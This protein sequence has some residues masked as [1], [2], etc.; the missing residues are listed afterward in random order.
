MLRGLEDSKELVY[1]RREVTLDARRQ[2]RHVMI[3]PTQAGT[4]QHGDDGCRMSVPT[5]LEFQ[6][7]GTVDEVYHG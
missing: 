6:G 3:L 7:P 4:I 1:L 5:K 2:G